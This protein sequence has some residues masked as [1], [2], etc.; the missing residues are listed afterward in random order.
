MSRISRLEEKLNGKIRE[1]NGRLKQLE[2]CHVKEAAKIWDGWSG[3][4]YY[5]ESCSE[6]GKQFRDLSE[7]ENLEI[8]IKNNKE[9]CASDRKGLEER[10][11]KLKEEEDVK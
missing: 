3:S 9:R 8:S 11:A 6:C 4:Y 7:Q 10:L 1:Y 2:C 5:V